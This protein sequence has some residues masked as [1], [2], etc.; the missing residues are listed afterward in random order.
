MD[1]VKLQKISFRKSRRN[2]KLFL[3]L[4]SLSYALLHISLYTILILII[5]IIFI[6]R[7]NYNSRII[8]VFF[9]IFINSTDTFH[10]STTSS[11]LPTPLHSI[12]TLQHNILWDQQS[13]NKLLPL[14]SF[15]YH[16][17]CLC[18]FPVRSVS[19][20]H[21]LS[22]IILVLNPTTSQ[23]PIESH[24]IRTGPNSRSMTI[25]GP[26]A[27]PWQWLWL[28]PRRWIDSYNDNKIIIKIQ[29]IAVIAFNLTTVNE[30]LFLLLLSIYYS[31]LLT[32]QPRQSLP[33]RMTKSC[34]APWQQRPAVERFCSWT[35]LQEAVAGFRSSSSHWLPTGS[36]IRFRPSSNK[37]H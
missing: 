15:L 11:I 13:C 27:V 21:H 12:S 26:A 19:P 9:I 37:R 3:I 29:E 32:L 25:A 8:V 6:Y 10:H 30:H 2:T 5:I 36:L 1:L 35:Q 7:L 22:C 14:P 16:F 4:S 31:T 20:H 24:P 28:K 34:R 18:T 23:I 17:H 33:I